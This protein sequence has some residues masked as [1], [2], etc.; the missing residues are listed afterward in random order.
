MPGPY[1]IKG[2]LYEAVGELDRAQECY[3]RASELA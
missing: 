2:D 3:R 1:R